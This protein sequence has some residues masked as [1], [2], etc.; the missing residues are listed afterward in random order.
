[1]RIKCGRH[2]RDI[3][4]EVNPPFQILIPLLDKINNSL[5]IKQQ[6]PDLA[7]G[8]PFHDLNTSLI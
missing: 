8:N 1:M 4:A 3:S 5:Q 2:D 6:P 7:L